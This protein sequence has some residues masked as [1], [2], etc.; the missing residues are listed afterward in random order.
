MTTK[1][2]VKN[3]AD[4]LIVEVAVGWT[5]EKVVYGQGVP[6]PIGTVLARVNSKVYPLNPAGAGDEAVAW[7]IAGAHVDPTH[8]DQTGLAIARGATV[9]ADA[10]EWPAGI[11]AP[12]KVTALA[13]L[14]ARG[15]VARTRL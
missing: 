1:T 2:L 10:L 8:G 12:A 5:K 7:G 13:E 11:T 3:L 4:V 15:I 9:D 14:D 6:V